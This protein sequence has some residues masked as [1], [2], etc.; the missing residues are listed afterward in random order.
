MGVSNKINL[1]QRENS[2][3]TDSSNIILQKLNY[4]NAIK[5]L[6]I[7]LGVDIKTNWIL[8]DKIDTDIQIFDYNDLKEKTISNNKNIKNQYYNIQLSKQDIK[9]AMSPFYPIISLNSGASYNKSTYDIGDLSSTINNTGTSI[10]YF[11][12]FS[13][14][15]RIFDG[16]KLYQNLR[17]LKI[18]EEIHSLQLEK[19]KK[20]VLHQLSLTEEKYNH[21]ITAFSLNKKAFNIAETNYNLAT[22]KKNRGIINSFTLRDIEIAYITSGINAQQ[23][24]YRLMESKIALLKITGGI[25]QNYTQK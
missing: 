13:I 7:T 10:N 5:N 11:A 24:A 6:N 14:N 2:I 12:N 16:G 25:I 3:L 1:L 18:Q 22:D 17:T 9:L 21:C 20:E 19:I 8:T 23:S 15:L 4:K